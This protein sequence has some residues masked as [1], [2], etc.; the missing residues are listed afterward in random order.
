MITIDKISYSEKDII[1]E[2]NS[3]VYKGKY[4]H[5]NAA[6]KK[7]LCTEI[8]GEDA[9]TKMNHPNVVKLLG[10]VEQTGPFR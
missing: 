3:I 4:G 9:L 6:V 7:M 1:G 10:D 2:G 8:T 5:Q